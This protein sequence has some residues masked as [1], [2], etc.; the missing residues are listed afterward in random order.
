MPR[1]VLPLLLV[2]AAASPAAAQGV[3]PLNPLNQ[4]NPLSPLDT[5]PD[6]LKRYSECM[7]LARSEPLKAL[8]VAEKWHGEG[9]GLAARHCVAVAMFEAGRYLPAAAQF[10]AIA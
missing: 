3:G 2:L 6:H 1:Q 7:S 8:P 9:G 4:L 10:E 5:A